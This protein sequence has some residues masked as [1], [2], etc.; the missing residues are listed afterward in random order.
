MYHT[1]SYNK[2]DKIFTFHRQIGN[3]ITKRQYK[4]G[5]KAYLLFALMTKMPSLNWAEN[6]KIV[7]VSVKKINP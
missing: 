7:Y 4:A 6:K 3:R 5:T 1:M 2:K